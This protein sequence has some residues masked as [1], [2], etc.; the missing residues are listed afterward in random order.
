M[1]VK[2]TAPQ[3]NTPSWHFCPPPRGY[4]WLRKLKTI[5]QSNTSTTFAPQRKHA[6]CVFSERL[7]SQKKSGREDKNEIGFKPRKNHRLLPVDCHGPGREV[8]RCFERRED[9]SP[10]RWSDF[11]SFASAEI[12]PREHARARSPGVKHSS[13]PQKVARSP[14]SPNSARSRTST[15]SR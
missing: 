9:A 5:I 14:T 2:T 4:C 15:R 6:G 12:G 13:P 8:A 7:T 11:R 1:R 3:E 10:R